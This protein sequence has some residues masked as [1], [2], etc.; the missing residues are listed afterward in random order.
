M[1]TYLET[2][3][4]FGLTRKQNAYALLLA[5]PLVALALT[6]VSV[7]AAMLFG[8]FDPLGSMLGFVNSWLSY[9]LGWFIVIGYQYRRVLTAFVSTTVGVALV[10]SGIAP[11]PLL[12][13]ALGMEESVL[14]STGTPLLLI[15]ILILAIIP[16]TRR[17]PIKV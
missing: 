9:L 5:S 3:L 10:F 4:N 16:L 7:L 12:P 15:I 1:S 13:T 14:L 8:G 2:M 11:F 6:L 17:I